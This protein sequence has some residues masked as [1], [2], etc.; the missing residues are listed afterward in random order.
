MRGLFYPVVP[1]ESTQ[2][3]FF[4]LFEGH[5][6]PPTHLLTLCIPG[7]A[8]GTD[9]TGASHLP[10]ALTTFRGTAVFIENEHHLAK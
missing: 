3:E 4:P 10:R 9:A 2:L 8:E 5:Y 6:F 1:L 7:E